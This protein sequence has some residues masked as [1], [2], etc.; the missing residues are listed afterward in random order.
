MTTTSS[1][2]SPEV[3]VTMDNVNVCNFVHDDNAT[4]RSLQVHSTRTRSRVRISVASGGAGER[5]MFSSVS[6]R[7]SSFVVRRSSS[8]SALLSAS[9]CAQ[10]I[11]SPRRPRRFG[12]CVW[13]EW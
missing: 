11:L 3:N 4:L 13:G 1:T 2:L 9:L 7:K 5:E 10:Y 12:K 8:K 6:S